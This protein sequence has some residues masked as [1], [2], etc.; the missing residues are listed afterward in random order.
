[1]ELELQLLG[2]MQI[3]ELGC[4]EV[5]PWPEVL[6]QVLSCSSEAIH[7]QKQPGDRRLVL[8]ASEVQYERIKAPIVPS[9]LV[10]LLLSSLRYL[11]FDLLCIE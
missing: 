7:T 6:A 8:A 4:L 1:M 11:T 10:S 9:R 2:L 3:A 5:P